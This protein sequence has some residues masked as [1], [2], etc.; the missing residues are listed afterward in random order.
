MQSKI[1]HPLSTQ[2][3]AQGKNES[4][5][6]SHTESVAQRIESLFM[7]G[8]IETRAPAPLDVRSGS[9]VVIGL[10]GMQADCFGADMSF[11]ASLSPPKI[12]TLRPRG[13]SSPTSSFVFEG[14]GNMDITNLL[15]PSIYDSSRVSSQTVLENEE[16]CKSLRGMVTESSLSSSPSSSPPIS[17]F[18]EFSSIQSF[19]PPIQHKDQSPKPHNAWQ[20]GRLERAM[21]QDKGQTNLSSIT[22]QEDIYP[23]EE[24]SAFAISIAQ[25]IAN[26]EWK[27]ALNVFAKME[28][29]YQVTPNVA[30]F[31][32]SIGACAA[33]G[34]WELALRFLTKMEESKTD[35]I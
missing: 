12:A 19:S 27:E 30:C 7:D 8:F 16:H 21:A 17:H 15:P 3:I 10:K 18:E 9:E 1:I 11:E 4:Q 6:G 24:A 13:S 32:E 5:T 14:L 29:A 31:E 20:S 2:E 25:I 33:G 28:T 23:D 35:S 26:G 22:A 34:Q